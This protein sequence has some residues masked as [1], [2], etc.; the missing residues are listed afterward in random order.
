MPARPTRRDKCMSLEEIY[1]AHIHDH[2]VY[3]T[4]VDLFDRRMTR[5]FSQDA[6]ISPY[7][8]QHLKKKPEIRMEQNWSNVW[9]L[10]NLIVG[11]KNIMTYIWVEENISW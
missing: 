4:Y 1:L 3:F 7:N 11:V 9:V 10:V 5:Y 8:K 6:S 2:C